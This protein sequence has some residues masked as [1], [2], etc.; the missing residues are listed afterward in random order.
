MTRGLRGCRYESIK[1]NPFKIPGDEG[2]MGYTFVDA[3]KCG[4]VHKEGGSHRSWTRRWL[5]VL[6]HVLYYFKDEEDEKWAPRRPGAAPSA[7]CPARR[8]LGIIPL[9]DLRVTRTEGPRR[10][11]GAQSFHYFELAGLD[12]DDGGP[13][14]VKGCK[15]SAS[16]PPGPG[17]RACAD[18]AAG[19]GRKG[20][21]VEGNH[22]RYIF[23]VDSDEEA[24]SW[25][26]CIEINIAREQTVVDLYKD[27]KL[28]QTPVNSPG[29]VASPG[30]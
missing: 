4:W 6:N 9:E 12:G 10:A 13:G 28:R 11:K 29:S 30:P 24:D 3:D 7:H 18:V 26:A 23:R 16:P 19:A 15:T 14:R 2:G 27:R 20:K 5:V 17:A 1:T 25:V 21:V 8:P 22:K